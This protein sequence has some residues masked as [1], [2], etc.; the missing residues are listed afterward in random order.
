MLST[1]P[2]Y[3]EKFQLYAEKIHSQPWPY[4]NMWCRV[5]KAVLPG[6]DTIE[7]RADVFIYAHL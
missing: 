1:T 5:K 6:I 4:K 7:A 3:D 2:L